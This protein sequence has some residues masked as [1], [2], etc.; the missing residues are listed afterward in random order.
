MKIR[1]FLLLA[2]LVAWAPGPA[3]SASPFGAQPPVVEPG[4]PRIPTDPDRWLPWRVFTWREG[5]KPG[6][7][8][9][10]QDGQGYI[11]A[12]GPVR[13]NGRTWQR[14]EVP[15]EAA[16]VQIWSTLAG[17]DG[18]LWLGKVSGGLLRLRNGVWTRFGAGLPAGLVQDMVEDDGGTVWV[19]ST[20]LG[21]CHAD[22]CSE[23]E[24]L[25]GWTI[26]KLELTRADD[27]RPALWIGTSNGL[28]RLDGIDGPS[29]VLS[30]P[31]A[32]PAVL[33]DLSIRGLAET[34]SADGVR[35][36]WVATDAG[37][38]RLRQGRW[39]RYDAASG[40]PRGPVVKLLAARSAAGRPIVWAGS[41]HSG[42]IRFDDDGRWRLFDTRSGLPTGYVYNLLSTSKGTGEPIL[43]AATPGGLVRL[44]REQWKAVDS[45]SGLPNDIAVGLGEATFPD[46][47]RTY[48]IGTVGG[49]VRFTREGWE[50]FAP[51]ANEA[52]LAVADQK[53]PAG[54]RAFWMGTVD[55]LRRYA[56][57]R[58]TNFTSRNSPMPNDW[59]LSLLSAPSPGG[60]VLWTGTS[61]G[62]ARFEREAWTVYRAG[63]SELPG[64]EVRALAWTPLGT[65][66]VLWAGTDRG[67]ARFAQGRWE[68]PTVPCL[69]HPMIFAVH[70]RMERDGTGWLWIGT[71]GGVARARLDRE[72]RL[73]GP[74]E[75]LSDR[76]RPALSHLSVAQIQTD[77][78]GRAYLFTDWGVNRLTLDPARGLTNA[79]VEAFDAGDGL[80][81]MEFNRASFTDHLGRIW[82]A[83]AGGA[84][85][86]DPAS[87]ERAAAPRQAAPLLFERTLVGGR[88]RALAPGIEL[89]HD[90]SSLEFQYALLSFR[91]EQMTQYRTQ[92]VGL[93]EAPSPWTHEATAV[94]NRLPPGAYTFRVWGRDGNGTV[95]GPIEA[96]FRIL[97]PPWLAAWAI[98]LYVAAFLGLGYSLTQWRVKTLARRAAALEAQIAERTRELEDA[99]RKLEQASLTDPLTGLSNRRFLTLNIEPDLRQAVRN[100]LGA[101]APR[102]R[103]S[104]LIFY[105]L[106]IDH[107]KQL[108]DRA[109][110]AAGD[111]V[112]MEIARRLREAAR[113]TDAVIRW[114]GEEFLIVSRWTDR[115]NGEV[116]AVRLLEAVAGEPFETGGDAVLTMT[117]SVGW[118]PYPWRPEDPD[119]VHYEHVLSLADRALYLAKR[120]GRNRAVGVLPAPESL[121]IPDGLLEEQEGTE[122]VLVRSIGPPAA[123]LGLSVARPPDPLVVA[124]PQPWNP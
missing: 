26:R 42:L 24:A 103:N 11:W 72:G 80:P 63:P 123:P 77:A 89:P 53:G 98:A 4:P 31:F 107:F 88:E 97:R 124:S 6:A 22:R 66:S 78:W 12:D 121:D 95:S 91:R 48:W 84:A 57:G 79:R 105:F 36:L 113:T 41:F 90:Q 44:E 109:G 33:P 34:V 8:A 69:P 75:A 96:R 46:G 27:G 18:S 55:G 99:N 68:T 51:A 19:G 117:C 104:D 2:A 61:R 82:A 114:G 35:S 71:Q 111:T 106:D 9:L 5:V 118:A 93:E 23:V 102:E 49:M 122:V 39:T 43:W 100:V 74:C 7:P 30:P 13:Y 81:G 37:V 29:P 47:L 3:W 65:G 15:G 25:R 14:V 70:P 110:H 94:Y 56:G 86:L 60:P 62:L 119:A 38:A 50:R 52:V 87:P 10:V 108:N 40:F 101:A 67:L 45:R 1:S 116:L 28:L 112:L 59:V 58:W 54:E 64:N 83:A 16:P 21:R 20:G 76:T 120:E 32:D 73:Q 85:I 92:L 115:R 17:R